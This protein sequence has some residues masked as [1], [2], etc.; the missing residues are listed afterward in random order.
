MSPFL[1]DSVAKL[2]LAPERATLIQEQRLMRNIDSKNPFPRFDYCAPV[3]CRRVLQQYPPESGQ[4]AD[5]SVGPRCADFVAK[6][7]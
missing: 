3:T 4:V 5:G 7:R 1:A 6:V 2:F